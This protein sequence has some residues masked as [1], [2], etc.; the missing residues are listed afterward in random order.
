[1]TRTRRWAPIIFGVTVFVVFLA[2]SAAVF[3][4]SWVREHLE[5][6]DTS[7]QRAEA[8]FEDI[9]QRYIAKAPLLEMR[10]AERARR[11]A[12]PDT[13]PRVS[14]TTLHLLAWDEDERQLVR[15]ELPF[16]LLRLKETP[17]RF[18]TYAS[19]LDELNISLTA[20]E[21]ERYGPGI[22]IDVSREGRDRALLWVE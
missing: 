3:G 19:G 12:P 14:L 17:I 15:F 20:A 1:M 6:E 10:G 11:N 21:I 8:T 22:I 5:I 16:W 4:V 13:A 18:G 9:R 2:I 7:P